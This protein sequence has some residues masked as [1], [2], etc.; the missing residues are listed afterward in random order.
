MHPTNELII[1]VKDIGHTHM[2]RAS[3]RT[4]TCAQDFPNAARAV[5]AKVWP[6]V[7]FTLREVPDNRPG[8]RSFAAMRKGPAR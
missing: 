7:E 8:Y 1:A 3:G 2:A 5:V 6:G 4:A